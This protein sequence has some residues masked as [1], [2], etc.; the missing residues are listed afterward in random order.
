MSTKI[1][2]RLFV[3]DAPL[4]VIQNIVTALDPA[5]LTEHTLMLLF[6]DLSRV[7]PI[8][9]LPHRMLEVMTEYFDETETDDGDPEPVTH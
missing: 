4:Q 1:E 5:L 3:A 9:E 2:N 8:E 6:G 7:L